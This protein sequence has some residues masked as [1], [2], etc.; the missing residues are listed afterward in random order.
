MNF[1]TRELCGVNTVANTGYHPCVKIYDIL[2]K[3]INLSH[4]QS[5]PLTSLHLQIG[6]LDRCVIAFKQTPTAPASVMPSFVPEPTRKS[7]ESRTGQA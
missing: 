6:D 7:S 5:W 3:K 1:V 4:L 2:K